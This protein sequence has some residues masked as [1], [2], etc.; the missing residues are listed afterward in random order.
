[1]QIELILITAIVSVTGLIVGLKWLSALSVSTKP[2]QKELKYWQE[3]AESQE[4]EAKYWKGKYNKK[5]QPPV[6]D[7]EVTKDNLPNVIGEFFPLFSDFVP[8]YLQPFF[9]NPT[10]QKLLV[11][12]AVKNP[13]QAASLIGRFF[14]KKGK[15]VSETVDNASN[16]IPSNV[17]IY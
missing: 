17:E 5:D 4:D 10:L 2:L 11:D 14:S 3:Y 16:S 6:F 9:K 13:D 7:G 1:M 15:T 8:K 12:W